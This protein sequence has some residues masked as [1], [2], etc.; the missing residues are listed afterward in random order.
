MIIHNKYL[1]IS[2]E[3][4]NKEE[5]ISLLY[6]WLLEIEE[7]IVIMDIT[8][9]KNSGVGG[10][11][12]E[13]LTRARKLQGILKNQIQHRISE[14]KKKQRPLSEFIIDIIKDN[15]SDSDWELIIKKAIE[16]KSLENGTT[17]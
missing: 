14:V 2:N 10:E 16:L 12:F 8:I 15:Y 13:R 4:V 9:R 3:D 1:N 11:W 17:Y 7:N 5:D 6:K